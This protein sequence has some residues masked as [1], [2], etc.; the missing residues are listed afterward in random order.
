[1]TRSS[2][3]ISPTPR[4][5]H[6]DAL[7]SFA[8][9]YGLLVHTATLGVRYPLTLISDVSG[10]FRMGTF[11]CVSGFF[12]AM[13]LRRY[14]PALFLKK[15]AL[16]LLVPLVCGLVF[17]NPLTNWLI[18]QWHNPPMPFLAFLRSASEGILEPYRGPIVWH[19]HLWFLISLAAYVA[20]APL[21]VALAPRAPALLRRLPD[22]LAALPGWLC[23]VVVAALIALAALGLR[24]G[25][26]VA[27]APLMRGWADSDTIWLVRNTLYYWPMFLTGILIFH[28]QGFAARF[29]SFSL[30]ALVLGLVAVWLLRRF[31]PEGGNLWEVLQILSRAFLTTAAI[32]ALMAIFARWF[33]RPGLLSGAADAVYSIYILHFLVIY[34][35][36]LALRPLGLGPASLFFAVAGLTFVAVFALHRFIVAPVP[37]LSLMFNGKPFPPRKKTALQK[38]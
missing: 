31:V 12:A 23:V 16:A 25:Y 14:G 30:P 18:W 34:L 5:H 11:F 22:R 6:L 24:L 29:Q 7:R 13:V 36:A 38:L 20:S 15:R 28:H 17:L 26:E 35:I 1:M 27:L 9:L 3:P 8:I 10:F 32:A 19:L 21:A 4:L 2:P 33:Q 37:L